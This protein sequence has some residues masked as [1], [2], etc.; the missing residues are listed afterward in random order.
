MANGD[1]NEFQFDGKSQSVQQIEMPF[2]MRHFEW[3]DTNIEFELIPLVPVASVGW[4][5][6]WL[7]GR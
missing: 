4:S 2:Y 5:V 3:C 7:D 6:G 1:T